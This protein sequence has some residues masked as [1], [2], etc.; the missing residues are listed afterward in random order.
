MVDT[1]NIKNTLDLQSTFN[2]CLNIESSTLKNCRSTLQPEFGYSSTLKQ[3]LSL[4]RWINNWSFWKTYF[5]I[6]AYFFSVSGWL[7]EKWLI[8]T[9]LEALM[10]INIYLPRGSET[11]LMPFQGLESISNGNTQTYFSPTVLQL[12]TGFGREINQNKFN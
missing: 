2:C 3:L 4:L 12:S 10:K 6:R 7:Y 8:K 11:G 1:F 5:H 9:L